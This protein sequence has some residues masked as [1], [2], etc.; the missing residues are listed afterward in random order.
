MLSTMTALVPSGIA[1][2]SRAALDAYYD[3]LFARFLPSRSGNKLVRISLNFGLQQ[4]ATRSRVARERERCLILGGFDPS[5]LASGLLNAMPQTMVQ[6]A[7]GFTRVMA[8]EVA[9]IVDEVRALL[10]QDGM[11]HDVVITN[12]DWSSVP[13]VPGTYGLIVVFADADQPVTTGCIAKL[14][15]LVHE[16]GQVLVFEALVESRQPTQF[17]SPVFVGR[18]G[19]GGPDP[20]GAISVSV[21]TN[22]QDARA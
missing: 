9:E 10:P 20:E 19:I 22:Y 12:D 11:P 6:W 18:Y 21:L 8:A 2:E 17:L 1:A 4:L 16:N 3:D 14:R 15:R 7:R 5:D 13:A